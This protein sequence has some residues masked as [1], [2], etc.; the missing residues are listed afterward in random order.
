MKVYLRSLNDQTHFPIEEGEN[1]LVGRLDR[2]DVVLND[3]SVSSQHARLNLVDGVLMVADLNSTNGT[4]VNYSVLVEPMALMDGDTVE[5]GNM[6]FTVDGPGLRESRDAVTDSA[7]VNEFKPLEM[8][9]PLDAT[10]ALSGFSDEDLLEEESVSTDLEPVQAGGSAFRPEKT[11][12]M[13]PEWEQDSGEE[14]G[15]TAEEPEE[16]L[17]SPLGAVLVS[18]LFLAGFAVLTGLHLWKQMPAP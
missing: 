8:T 7:F 18:I 16:D 13:R 15:F 14:G 5:F 17:Y 4:R 1:L 10:M 12:A 11:A 9:G 2:C 3:G 6:S